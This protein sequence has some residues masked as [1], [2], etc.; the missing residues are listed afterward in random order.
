[1][2]ETKE[3]EDWIADIQYE[4]YEHESPIRD[5]GVFDH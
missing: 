2:E 1:M 5:H 3:Y 4:E